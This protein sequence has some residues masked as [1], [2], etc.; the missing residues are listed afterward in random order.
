MG[1]GDAEYQVTG[2]FTADP[3]PA[4]FTGCHAHGSDM[5]VFFSVLINVC[6]SWGV[7]RLTLSPSYCLDP[8]GGEV[9]VLTEA[10]EEHNEPEHKPSGIPSGGENCHFHAGVE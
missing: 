9:Q 4:Q 8:V 2:T 7:F 3:P 10:H 1:P 5:Y 6:K